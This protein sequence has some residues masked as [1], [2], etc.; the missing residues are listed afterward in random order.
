MAVTVD[1]VSGRVEHDGRIIS[2]Q[3][4]SNTIPSEY[5]F[6]D[7]VSGRMAG[8]K[9]R[10]SGNQWLS[11][12]N[13]DINNG[14]NGKGFVQAA[15]ASNVTIGTYEDGNPNHYDGQFIRIISG[16]GA[17]QTRTI[18]T[19]DTNTQILSLS[20]NWTVTPNTTSVYEIYDVD[21][22]IWTVVLEVV[23]PAQVIV[24]GQ[25]VTAFVD[26]GLF[27]DKFGNTHGGG[28]VVLTNNSM[29][30]KTGF[31][32]QFAVGAGGITLYVAPGLSEASDAH[33]V[34]QAQN[35]NTPLNTLKQAN[36][37]LN[38]P[39]YRTT[40]SRIKVLQGTTSEPAAT[41][42]IQAYGSSSLTTP[43]IIESYW[44]AYAS[45][46]GRQGIRPILY[47]NKDRYYGLYFQD[48]GAV[49]ENV[50]IRG[51][52]LASSD[53]YHM[54]QGIC[55][56]FGVYGKHWIVDDCILEGAEL[57][58]NIDSVYTGPNAMSQYFT[59]LRCIFRDSTTVGNTHTGGML[60]NKTKNLLISQC[61]IDN[62]GK[63]N[64]DFT[65]NNFFSH[66]LYLN[67]HP[68]VVYR[69]YVN[70]NGAY[71]IQCRAGGGVH[72]TIIT[73]NAAG[74]FI[75][76]KGGR[77]SLNYVGLGHDLGWGWASGTWNEANKSITKTN[78]FNRGGAIGDQINIS[79][80]QNAK[81]GNY[82]TIV[83]TVKTVVSGVSFASPNHRLIKTGAFSSYVH[84]PANRVR[85]SGTGATLGYYGIASGDANNLYLNTSPT[86][87]TDA[88][89]LGSSGLT[90]LIITLE[91]DG[92]ILSSSINAQANGNNDICGNIIGVPEGFGLEFGQFIEYGLMEFNIMANS[93]G[94]GPFTAFTHDLTST[95]VNYSGQSH[96]TIRNNIGYEHGEFRTIGNVTSLESKRNIFEKH[97]QTY[98]TYSHLLSFLN[99]AN[100]DFYDGD[101]NI[102]IYDTGNLNKVLL[103]ED[104]FRSLNYF[105]SLSGS[106]INSL[107]ASGISFSYRNPSADLGTYFTSIDGGQNRTRDDYTRKLRNRP[108]NVWNSSYDTWPAIKFM[109][110]QFRTTLSVSG[111]NLLNFYGPGTEDKTLM[112]GLSKAVNLGKIGTTSLIVK[113]NLI[114]D[115]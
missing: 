81:K 62:C 96:L 32:K 24:N 39:L 103:I 43:Y 64:L 115:I 87:Y 19:H 6:P 106:D 13:V 54:D 26:A 28:S 86:L 73:D 31:T 12:V 92:I 51:M 49:Q 47:F 4:E 82:T 56:W 44:H 89:T 23:E 85:V 65:A 33:T 27:T 88:S 58:C 40:G 16:L 107:D 9:I 108:M 10:L 41:T 59:F 57:L 55:L 70:N 2:L 50:I 30:D 100:F 78:N 22:L 84:H 18:T 79:R 75:A 17:G 20:S 102:Y 74:S 60:T 46:G 42:Y 94:T 5:A 66:G 109:M 99:V 7:W 53:P 105:K 95:M 52:H 8:K 29:V 91:N 48:T 93:S 112:G 76:Q 77:F 14:V 36:D 61:V 90:N 114:S 35:I 71:G 69:S 98:S 113:T 1:L 111:T 34:T 72:K 25:S 38:D 67:N 110:D 97:L 63:K 11:L 37:L 101:D 15:T 83:D 104:I 80:G 21:K 3:F 68:V 45:G